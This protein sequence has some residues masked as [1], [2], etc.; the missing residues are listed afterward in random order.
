MVM[1]ILQGKKVSNRSKVYFI[2]GFVICINTLTCT[3]K[4]M[5]FTATKNGFIKRVT[6][7]A[8]YWFGLSSSGLNVLSMGKQWRNLGIKAFEVSATDVIF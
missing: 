2:P 7:I 1:W 8:C 5:G 3:Q 4:Q 6:R